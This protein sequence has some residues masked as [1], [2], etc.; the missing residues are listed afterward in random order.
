MNFIQSSM[1]SMSFVSVLD[2]LMWAED[3]LRLSQTHLD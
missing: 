3:F 1:V 2:I